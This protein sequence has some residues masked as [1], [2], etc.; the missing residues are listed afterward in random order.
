MS[1]NS[2]DTL[3]KLSA[4]A[5]KP[6][7]GVSARDDAEQF[8]R[9]LRQAAK[10]ATAPEPTSKP[11][12]AAKTAKEESAAVS[13]G[14]QDATASSDD[15]AVPTEITEQAEVSAEET[16]EVAE[17]D[18][19]LV[20]AAAA[21][22]AAQ[23]PETVPV[24]AVLAAELTAEP[25]AEVPTTGQAN[26]NA[27]ESI[28]GT[29]QKIPATAAQ[30]GFADLLPVVA[31]NVAPDAATIPS[32]QVAANLVPA[33]VTDQNLVSEDARPA[34]ISATSEGAPVVATEKQRDNRG[35]SPSSEQNL[36]SEDSQPALI[37]ATTEEAPIAATEKQRDDR[38][39]SQPSEQDSQD[40]PTAE[41]PIEVTTPVV[42]DLADVGS[43]ANKST[44]GNEKTTS[45]STPNAHFGNQAASQTVGD[46][47]GN[48][49]SHAA[50]GEGESQTPTI[51]RARFVQ[52][53]TNAFRAA[54]QNDGHIQLRLSPP[55]LGQLRIE[56]AVRNGVLSANLETETADAR[57]VLLDN[58]PALRQR[59]AEQD[60]RIDKFEVDIRRE[61]GQPDGQAGAQDR[62]AE[63][64]TQRASAQNRIR[65]AQTSDV[66]TTRVPRTQAMSADAGLDVRI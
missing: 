23:Q 34:L 29:D 3:I 8:D 7:A 60:I 22:I 17:V 48:T 12:A 64:N 62:Q 42:S 26:P 54:Q 37:S 43:D 56:I 21:A 15:D 5:A 52:R 31:N 11:H 63:Q 55:E 30:T 53:V 44:G 46:V 38:G 36:V 57:R 25:S 16:A 61:G 45:A 9:Y 6:A 28:P 20:S 35:E 24:V 58:L 27:E 51:D 59:L 41:L 32:E 47:S 13:T 1:S 40:T 65:A 66:I 49:E 33:E 2:I 10:A 4:P 18:E 14:E 19:L 50:R 39:G